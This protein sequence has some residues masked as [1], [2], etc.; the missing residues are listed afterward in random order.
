MG[1]KIKGQHMNRSTFRTIKDINGFVFSKARYMNGIGFEI[2]ARTPSTTPPPP[3]PHTHTLVTLH[4]Q[5]PPL[6][7]KMR[8]ERITFIDF[9]QGFFLHIL[10]RG[11]RY[12]T[13]IC[14]YWLSRYWVWL[15]IHRRIPIL[16]EMI[17]EVNI[18]IQWWISTLNPVHQ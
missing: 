14:N 5:P 6:V 1:I 8:L 16:T 4:P 13:M 2:L 18:G 11:L 12:K 9:I 10:K 7:L 17:A 3:P 15:D